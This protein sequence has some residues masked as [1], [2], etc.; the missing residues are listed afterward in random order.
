ML[1]GCLLFAGLFLSLI[2]HEIKAK[3]WQEGRGT[4]PNPADKRKN[5]YANDEAFN[6]KFGFWL[7]FG[8]LIII[9]L[10]LLGFVE[11]D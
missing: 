5:P 8:F 7:Y 2:I 9:L 10:G 1:F 3:V 11:D 4:N 6:F